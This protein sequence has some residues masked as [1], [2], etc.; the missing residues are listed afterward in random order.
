M[1]KLDQKGAHFH[2]PLQS[3]SRKYVQFLWSGNIYKFFCLHFRLGL[4]SLIFT[5]VGGM[6][7]Q[8]SNCSNQINTTLRKLSL[9]AQAVLPGHLH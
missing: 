1:C 2:V 9:S 8:S 5:K 3:A 6:N 7:K 4:V